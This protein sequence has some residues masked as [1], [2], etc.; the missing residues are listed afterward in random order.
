LCKRY[1]ANWAKYGNA[2]SSKKNQQMLDKDNPSLVVAFHNDID[3][4]KGTKNTDSSARK[5]NLEV[6]V[7]QSINNTKYK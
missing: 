2:T 6:Q 5:Q 3:K 1:K 7:I 4:S